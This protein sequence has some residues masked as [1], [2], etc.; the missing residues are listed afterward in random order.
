MVEINP[1]VSQL[2]VWILLYIFTHRSA[3][4]LV[5]LIID[6]YNQD[7]DTITGICGSEQIHQYAAI[8]AYWTTIEVREIYR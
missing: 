8:T 4:T 3:Y 7:R 2:L 6:T 1:G 5:S